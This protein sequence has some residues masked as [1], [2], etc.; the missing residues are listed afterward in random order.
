LEYSIRKVQENQEALQLNR[1]HQPLPSVDVNL[2]GK[3]ISNINKNTE[4]GENCIMKSFITFTINQLFG[5]SNQ[6][7]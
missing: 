1:T 6:G 3:N 4:A 2:L 7:R 5:W